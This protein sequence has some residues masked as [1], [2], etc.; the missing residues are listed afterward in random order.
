MYATGRGVKADPVQAARWHMIAR[1]GGDSDQFL[2]DFM[3]RMTAE[4]RAAAEKAAKPWLSALTAAP[5]PLAP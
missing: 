5:S 2:E 3:R 4:D 1:A